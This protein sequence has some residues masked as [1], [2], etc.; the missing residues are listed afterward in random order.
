M[1]LP[2]CKNCLLCSFPVFAS[3]SLSLLSA[4]SSPRTLHLPPGCLPLFPWRDTLNVSITPIINPLCSFSI[5]STDAP[6]YPCWQCCKARG[7]SQPRGTD[8]CSFLVRLEGC[9]FIQTSLPR[10]HIQKSQNKLFPRL[11]PWMHYLGRRWLTQG[12]GKKI[13]SG[14]RQQHE[15]VALLFPFQLSYAKRE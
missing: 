11:E 3:G 6:I 1:S 8:T 5:I 4:I 12:S 10:S 14:K 2:A 15:D 7:C 13:C 9:K